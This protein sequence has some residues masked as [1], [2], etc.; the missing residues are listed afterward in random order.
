[1][2]RKVLWSLC[3]FL[4]LNL[5][6]EGSL[7]LRQTSVALYVALGRPDL[8]LVPYFWEAK[9]KKKYELISG[10]DLTVSICT[11]RCSY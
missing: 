4:T 11:A 6:F 5:I 9:K 3:F 8:V 2:K 10:I 7:F 1:M